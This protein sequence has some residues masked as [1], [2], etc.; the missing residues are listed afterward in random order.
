MSFNFGGETIL[1]NTEVLN[2]A[3]LYQHAVI[4]GPES[5]RGYRTE[6]FW[7]KSSFHNNNELRYITNLR[8]YLLNAKIGLLAFFDDGRVWLPGEDSN[9][10]HT[11]YGAGILLAPFNKFCAQ[12][13]YGISS[14]AK[15]I[16][17]KFNTPIL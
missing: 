15:L 2:S 5:L 11:S 12:V 10:F 9:L 4:G 3:Q 1:G 17:L 16:Q 14:E 6:R 13:T 7:G 8:S